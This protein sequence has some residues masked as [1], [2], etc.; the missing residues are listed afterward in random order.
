MEDDVIGCPLA[1]SDGQQRA[2]S[3]LKTLL[4]FDT[5]NP[6]GNEQ[7]AMRWLAEECRQLGADRV[8][9]D[10]N[11]PDRPNLS[12]GWLAKPENTTGRPLVLSCHLDV[13]PA[14]EGE[15]DHP[16]FSAHDDGEDIWGRGA[17]DMKGFAAMA[18]TAIAERVRDLD[19]QPLTRDL[20]LLAVSDE[21]AGTAE[22]SRWVVENRPDFLGNDPEY[23]LNELG[24][25]TVHQN[26]HRFY[27]VQVA[28]KGVAWLKLTVDGTPGHSS[29]PAGDN[30]TA[31][32]A[33]AIQAIDEAQL[34]W[35]PTEEA[36]TQLEGFAKPLGAAAVKA[37]KLL[38]SPR[39]G[40]KFLPLL[41]KDRK[42]RPAVEAILRNT[43][44]PT[45]LLAGKAV[46]VLPGQAS[47]LIDGRIL[48]GFEAY[49][50]I[51]EL[52]SAISKVIDPPWSLKIEET[53][54]AVSFPTDTPLF[55]AIEK[56]I[57]EKDPG[58]HPVS[59]V[60]SG[61]TDSHNYEKLGAVCY[62]FY[63]LPLEEDFPFIELFHAHNERIPK[64]AYLQGCEWLAELLRADF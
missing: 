24:G 10:G 46:N 34:P 36:A 13:V 8:E 62:G 35:H 30:A 41:V 6:P 21:E 40:P 52:D 56:L 27:P 61:F 11:T 60:L 54:E 1:S 22:G 25:F 23:V 43:A 55:S 57:K 12:A 63:P 5:T 47:V 3:W 29:L 48:P 32:L 19:T 49:D 53:H 2:L 31:K 18:L 39:L 9:L 16:P 14:D 7:E 4:Q 37:S 51:K 28:E 45:K 26:G 59:S 17:I 33:R 58:A 42:R 15:W 38:L 20:Y 50:L 64:R 44:N